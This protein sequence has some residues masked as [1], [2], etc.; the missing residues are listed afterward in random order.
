MEGGPRT[1]YL[2]SSCFHVHP[3]PISHEAARGGLPILAIPSHSPT[4]WILDCCSVYQKFNLLGLGVQS[5]KRHILYAEGGGGPHESINDGGILV[6]VHRVMVC[7]TA[8]TLVIT[9]ILPC[10]LS[11][12]WMPSI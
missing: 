3:I 10:T 2:L 5:R 6:E 4:H 11:K 8:F 9:H 7:I 12:W 1:Y